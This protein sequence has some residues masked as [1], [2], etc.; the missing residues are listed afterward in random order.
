MCLTPT[1]HTVSAV[2][3]GQRA[4]PLN[5]ENSAYDDPSEFWRFGLMEEEAF[6]KKS[7]PFLLHES[8]TRL[9]SV[10]PSIFHETVCG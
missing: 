4:R 5:E 10:R 2:S 7:G 9:C 1:G 8:P 6:G 3:T